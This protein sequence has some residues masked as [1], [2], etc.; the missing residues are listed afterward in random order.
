MGNFFS[1]LFKPKESTVTQVP[2]Q[3]DFQTKTGKQLAEWVQ[4]YLANY[5]PGEAYSGSLTAPMTGLEATGQDQLKAFLA[6]NGTGDL[7]GAARKQ[8][9]DTLGGKYMDPNT[10]PWIS[11]M[12]K[13]SAS[14]LEGS[15]SDA[16]R[17]AGSRGTYFKRSGV[18][19]ENT[20]R[21]NAQGN[22]DVIIGQALEAER[23]RQYGAVNTAA[24]LDQYENQTVPLSKI[25]ASNKYGSLARLIQQGDLERRYADFTR[26]RGE[27]SS[28]PTI[29]QDLY[30]TKVDYGVKS[31]TSKA[32]S[33]LMKMLGEAIPV[34]GSYN[35]ASTGYDKN[36]TSINDAIKSLTK[37]L[38]A[39]GGG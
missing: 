29:A 20:L 25:D 4:K 26:Q 36:Q 35:T 10:N 8:T 6:A 3:E 17:T 23:A 21:E 2:M 37:I 28:L 5:T 1:D 31:V 18:Q 30:G 33:T 22:L 7:F 39:G 19:D 14:N 24:G 12:S 9:L 11:A 27:L 38:A 32:P 15:I 13:L 16:R 34:V